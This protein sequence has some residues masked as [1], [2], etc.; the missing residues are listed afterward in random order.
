MLHPRVLRLHEVYMYYCEIQRN[1]IEIFYLEAQET[2]IE[3]N[4]EFNSSTTTDIYAIINIEISI[5]SPTGDL[6]V[7]LPKTSIEGC[8]NRS[9]DYTD[10][11]PLMNC[12]T[13]KLP[14]AI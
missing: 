9:I 8:T 10:R 11:C 5:F 14:H 1:I 12:F 3:L 7:S 4:I 6:F 13:V 2:P